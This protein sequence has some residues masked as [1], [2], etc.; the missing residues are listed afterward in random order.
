MGKLLDYTGIVCGKLTIIKR[1]GKNHQGLATWVAKCAC[2]KEKIVVGRDIK[3]GHLKSCGQKGCRA[4]LPAGVAATNEIF[5]TY[6]ND[7]KRRGLEFEITRKDFDIL[8]SSNCYYCG[9]EPQQTKRP[10]YVFQDFK[11]NGIDRLNNEKGYTLENTVSCC[12]MCNMMK[13]KY[14]TD[15][16][17]EHVSDICAY[18]IRKSI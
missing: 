1:A 2:G 14:K 12:K 3:R 17:L 16:F 15:E 9:K 8:I 11:Y 13:W 6:R 5:L 7:A 4:S 18:Q 10:R